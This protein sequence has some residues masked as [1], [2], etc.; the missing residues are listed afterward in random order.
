M[1]FKRKNVTMANLVII[2]FI[3]ALM[4]SNCYI[5]RDVNKRNCLVVDPASENSE[6][7]IEYIEENGL[8]L[9][10]ILLTHEHTDH[11]WG[12]NALK[13]KYPNSIIVSSEYCKN[14]IKKESQSYFL[15]YNDDPNYHYEMAP[16]DKVIVENG[17]IINW[18]GIKIVFL[19]TPGHSMGSMCISIEDVLFTGDT[20][21]PFPPHLNKRYSKLDLFKESI[22]LINSKYPLETIIYPGHGNKLNL[23]EWNKHVEWKI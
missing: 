16:V 3:N 9:N 18:D 10:Y 22:N 20:I 12:V 7:E 23:K 11:T 14:N 1:I 21:M 15:L 17:T 4:S 8:V 6:K 2:R 13:E 5:I 19:L